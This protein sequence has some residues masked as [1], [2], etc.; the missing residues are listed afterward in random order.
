HIA[1]LARTE[2]KLV[3]LSYLGLGTSPAHVRYVVRR[4]RRILPQGT[5]ILVCYWSDKDEAPAASQLLTAAEADA[6][7]TSLPQAGEIFMVAA[8][9]ELK[10]VKAAEEPTSPPRVTP[11]FVRDNTKKREQKVKTRTPVS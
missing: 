3:C 11:F 5:G 9:G 7:A 2:A 1:S 6:Y 8:K 10:R 4:L